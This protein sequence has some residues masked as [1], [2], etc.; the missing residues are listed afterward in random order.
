MSKKI[1]ICE[2]DLDTLGLFSN[3]FDREYHIREIVLTFRSATGPPEIRQP[4]GIPHFFQVSNLKNK[5]MDAFGDRIT[6]RAN[7]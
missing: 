5:V 6:L 2:N 7:G 4:T 1:D 3:G